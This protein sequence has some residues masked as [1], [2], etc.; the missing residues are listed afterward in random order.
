VVTGAPAVVP[1]SAASSKV[2]RHQSAFPPGPRHHLEGK[3]ASANAKSQVRPSFRRNRESEQADHRPAAASS[4]RRHKPARI[5][6]PALDSNG[7]GCASCSICM[8]PNPRGLNA[9]QADVLDPI[10]A[11]VDRLDRYSR[12]KRLLFVLDSFGRALGASLCSTRSTS[13][14]HRASTIMLPGSSK[15][16]PRQTQP[17]PDAAHP[18]DRR[19]L[20]RPLPTLRGSFFLFDFCFLLKDASARPE[21]FFFHLKRPPP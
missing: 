6:S 11:K 17:K 20:S 13:R 7:R 19:Q 12:E 4:G 21:A 18:A 5:R 10:G 1:E 14:R 16:P 15:L 3:L 8:N 2:G 9:A